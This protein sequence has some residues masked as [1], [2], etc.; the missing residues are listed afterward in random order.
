[1][2]FAEMLSGRHHPWEALYNP[3]RIHVRAMMPALFHNGIDVAKELIGRYTKKRDNADDLALDSGKVVTKNGKK[4]ALYKDK[5][6]KLHAVSAVCTHMGC[7]VAWNDG[8]K[9]WDCPCHGSRFDTEGKVIQG[10]ASKDLARVEDDSLMQEEK[11]CKDCDCGK[12][13]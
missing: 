3:S 6:G 11:R 10:P 13:N 7:I 2:L 1:M 12:K 9:T 5:K 4:V 8:E